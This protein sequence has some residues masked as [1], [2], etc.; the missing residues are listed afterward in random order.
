[1]IGVAH[2]QSVPSIPGNIGF[3]PPVIDVFN[4]RY[5][6]TRL[7]PVQSNAVKVSL[8]AFVFPSPDTDVSPFIFNRNSYLSTNG[9]ATRVSY[10]HPAL[11]SE[12]FNLT[13][14]GSSSGLGGNPN[15]YA[16]S[17]IDRSGS[18]TTLLNALAASPI[19]VTVQNA[20]APNGITSLSFNTPAYRPNATP[21]FVRDV[22]ITGG[23]GLS[24][25][26]NW[27]L[28]TGAGPGTEFFPSILLHQFD[29]DASSGA[30]SNIKLVHQAFVPQGASSYTFDQPFSSASQTGFPI[31][32]EPG[33]HYQASVQ[34]GQYNLYRDSVL[35][36]DENDDGSF[37]LF[38]ISEKYVE[39]STRAL[40]TD[41]VLGDPAIFLPSVGPDGVFRFDIGVR[42]G[43]QVFI[44]PVVAVGYDYQIGEGDPLFS[45]VTL[46]SIGDGLF[47]L[48]LFDNGEFNLAAE[49]TAGAEYFFGGPGVDRFR[50]LGI[51]A[52]AGLDPTDTSAFVTALAFAADGRFTG[53][54]T[55][56][57]QDSFAVPEP[58]AYV[59]LLTG[60]GAM[61]L[62]RRRKQVLTTRM[63][64]LR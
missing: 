60:F 55:P 45:S 20:L 46:P 52:A 29:V 41:P 61:G 49:L 22:S 51:E 57:T 25:T 39:F 24:P 33:K 40:P 31:G 32:L 37:D 43:Q 3:P 38:G 64:G 27:T 10:S 44:D 14:R 42:Q 62:T 1:M 8:S 50:V 13:F 9:A 47:D 7:F 30:I 21:G 12:A 11:S 34:V 59:L 2:A 23:G 36:G 4:D 35:D 17:I 54:Q 15:V 16:D 58:A 48:Y 6:F 19:K 28:P 53:T 26:L 56:L 63:A 5:G 18:S